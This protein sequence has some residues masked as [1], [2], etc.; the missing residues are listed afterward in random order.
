M[1]SIDSSIETSKYLGISYSWLRQSR[2][3]GDGPPFI[4]IGRAIRYRKEDVD[5]WLLQNQRTNTL[6]FRQ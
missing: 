4:K 5:N 6:N 2:V 1:K 3:R